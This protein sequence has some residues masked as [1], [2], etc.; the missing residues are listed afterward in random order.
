M[1]ILC[2]ID[3]FK[4]TASSRELVSAMADVL[5]T[6]YKDKFLFSPLVFSDG[7]EGLLDCFSNIDIIVRE[8][9]GP[10]PSMKV[11]A[12]FGISKDKSF[13][14]VEMAEAAGLFLVSKEKRNPLNTTTYGVGELVR[15]AIVEFGVKKVIIGAGG[16]ATVDGGSGFLQGL[17]CEFFDQTG[18]KISSPL[19][20]AIIHTIKHFSLSHLKFLDEVEFVVLSD[21]DTP[22][23]KCAQVFGPQKGASPADVKFLTSSI[24]S[25]GCNAYCPIL[26]NAM[27]L[28]GGGAAGGL[29]LAVSLLGGHIEKGAAYV[30]NMA[31]GD[32]KLAMADVVI[33]GEGCFDATT[34]E[35]KVIDLVKR[36]II[37]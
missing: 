24:A 3:S 5:K 13:A 10:L 25:L 29:S 1:N 31:K 34:Q 20:G 21:V 27:D 2:C 15:H 6:D 4:G 17:G 9:V 22:L 36:K 16:S 11:D 32:E 8:V 33:S 30:W 23:S 26:P 18:E 37:D 7:G 28:V 35:G 14:V 12:K 19:T